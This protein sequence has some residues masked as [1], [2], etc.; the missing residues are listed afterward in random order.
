MKRLLLSS[1]AGLVL[2]TGSALA[3][4]LSTPAP[5]Y[6]APPPAPP[7]VSWTGCYI[8]GGV[9]YGMYNTDSNSETSPGLVP[10]GTQ[11]TNGGRG[12]LGRLGGGCDYQFGVGGLGNFVIGAFGDYDFMSLSGT[13]GDP[14]GPVT[15]GEKERGAWYVGGRLGYLV[16]PWLLGY[17]DGGY[18]QTRFD[19]VNFF[20]AGAVPVS[21]GLALSANTYSGWFI[22]GGTEYALNMP[23]MPIHGL[24]WR[25]E[26]RFAEY[27]TADVPIFVT[28]TSAPFGVA[29]HVSPYVQTITSGL[30]WR[31]N[32]GG[33]LASRY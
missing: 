19:Q 32:F 11:V 31:F 6:K 15:G 22:G 12:W 20:G 33:P 25:T 28:A 1:L 30:V 18:T 8:D 16:T 9:G 26:Y 2:T 10:I 7:A 14:S 5:M 21:T 29:E 24:F 23:W 27:Q 3:A 4:D 17:V 13:F